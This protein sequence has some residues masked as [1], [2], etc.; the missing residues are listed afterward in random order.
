[1]MQFIINSDDFGYCPGINAAILY[2]HTHG[3]LTS[4]TL[5]ANGLFFEQAVQLA[6][7]HPTLGVG[8][9]LVMTFGRPLLDDMPS[10]TDEAGNFLKRT[11]FDEQSTIDAHE[12][13][14]EWQAQIEKVKAAG[15]IPTHLDSHHHMHNFNE[16]TRE[17]IEQLAT[18]YQLPVRGNFEAHEGLT[19]VEHF[20]GDFDLVGMEP[21]SKQQTY[22][23]ELLATLHRYESVEMMCHAGFLDSVLVANSSFTEPRMYQ[24]PLLTDSILV[25][26]IQADSTIKLATYNDLSSGNTENC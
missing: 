19:T 13:Y 15:I 18:D 24:V 12:L 26:R 5:M 1:M 16:T 23:E 25:D 3:I 10:L 7:A 22:V 6:K 2:C 8:V 9:H 11:A 21:A 20:V 14:R 17:V 4:T